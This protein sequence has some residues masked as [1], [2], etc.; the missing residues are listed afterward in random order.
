MLSVSG[1]LPGSQ[2]QTA[3]TDQSFLFHVDSLMVKSIVIAE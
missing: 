1:I 2:E 3:S